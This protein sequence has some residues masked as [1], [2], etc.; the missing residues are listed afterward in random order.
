[1]GP[2]RWVH[3]PLANNTQTNAGRAR[4]PGRAV[5]SLV[6]KKNGAFSVEVGGD[7]AAKNKTPRGE[8]L[9]GVINSLF[10]SVRGTHRKHNTLLCKMPRTFRTGTYDVGPTQCLTESIEKKHRTGDLPPGVPR[11]KQQ[12]QQQQQQQCCR[13]ERLMFP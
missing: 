7:L 12:Q 8:H 2:T 11:C 4:L 3:L 13:N 9:R 1:M 10:F 6:E 5:F